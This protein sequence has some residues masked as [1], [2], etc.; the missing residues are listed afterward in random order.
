[1][2]RSSGLALLLCS[3]AGT[4][5]AEFALV[6]DYE[7]GLGSS[8]WSQAGYG[9]GTAEVVAD[10]IVTTG[11]NQVLAFNAGDVNTNN[12]TV[13][14]P[15]PNIVADSVGTVFYRVAVDSSASGLNASLMVSPLDAPTSYG[16]ANILLNPNTSGQLSYRNGSVYTPVVDP[17]DNLTWYKVWIVADT[18]TDTSDLYLQGGSYAVPTLVADDF[19]FRKDAV[20]ED[21]KTILFLANSGGA[22]STDPNYNGI[23]YVD[24][25]YVD[26]S[27]ANMADPVPTAAPAPNFTLVDNF[28]AGL[29][30][31]TVT[32]ASYGTGSA[33]I[34]NDPVPST[35]LYNKVLS[36]NAGD[37]N[38]NNLV[39]TTPIPNIVEG[40]YGTVF[41]RFAVDSSSSATNGTLAISPL[42]MPGVNV[43]GD[44]NILLN[45][46]TSE[47]ISYRDGTVYTPVVDPRENL[48]WYQA[49]YLIDTASDTSSLYL[50][51]GAYS[52]PTLVAED[53]AFRK[54]VT[55]EDLMSVM[56]LLNSG[57]AG[58]SV[59]NFNGSIFVDDIYVDNS[60][61]TIA[62]PLAGME[63]PTPT[64][65]F[66]KT[67]SSVTVDGTKDSAYAAR[68]SLVPLVNGEISG[69]A[70]LSASLSGTW[71]E[72][73]VYFFVDVTDDVISA[74]SG[75]ESF[76]D[77]SIEF[78]FDPGNDDNGSFDGV[79]DF[80]ITVHLQ[81]GT[82]P[83]LIT[84]S[85][86][87][88]PPSGVDFTGTEAA[89]VTTAGGYAVELFVPFSAL[90]FQPGGDAVLGFALQINDDDGVDT[91]DPADGTGER[92]GYITWSSDGTRL[93]S[94]TQ[95]FG[96]LWLWAP[97]VAEV[98]RAQGAIVIDG[99]RDG[100][101]NNQAMVNRTD[102]RWVRNDPIPAD[103]TSVT[104]RALYDED[105]L[106]LLFNV[107]DSSVIAGES[108]DI[109]RDDGIE[110]YFDGDNN[111]GGAFDGA[112]DVKITY[113]LTDL[114]GG[115]EIVTTA[116]FPSPPTGTDF[117]GLESA[118]KTTSSGWA[119]EVK[120]PWSIIGVTPEPGE[121]IGF[122]FLV[123]DD[124]DGGD[125]ENVLS[126]SS[127]VNL[128]NRT[129]AL[130]TLYLFAPLETTLPESDGS[131]IV[132]DG[133]IDTGYGSAP[134]NP[135]TRAPARASLPLASDLSA[136]WLGV[137][138]DSAIYLVVDVYDN[139]VSADS[140]S[141]PWQDDGIEFF[142]DP[143]NDSSGT[144]DGVEDVKIT[145]TLPLDG[146]D[147]RV[148]SATNFPSPPADTDFSGLE[149]AA[150]ETDTGWRV[151]LKVPL[152]TLRIGAPFGGWTMG[153]DIVISD[154]DFGG[155]RENNLAW[156]GVGLT[157]NQTEIYG[158]VTFEGE[159]RFAALS[160]ASPVEGETDTY[161]SWIGV[162]VEGDG[163]AGWILHEG[164][165]WLYVGPKNGGW[166]Y[167]YSL[168]TWIY[169]TPM[170]APYIFTLDQ[171]WT[172]YSYVESTASAYL[173]VYATQSWVAIP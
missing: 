12:L 35:S 27:G 66:L 7:D 85:N 2:A 128:N 18:T 153:M 92:S 139:D 131:A 99:D 4:A 109:W 39:V 26:A 54:N 169:S 136:W 88:T 123:N 101:F 62:N 96:N 38:T 56:F 11:D 130:G 144:F 114:E 14:T 80:K 74:D 122:G 29:D 9:T 134:W 13:V 147:L 43:W 42:E 118:Y 3:L 81:D 166:M 142:F 94:N 16:N 1:M 161:E 52:E 46:N 17:R 120:L 59:P 100:T 172:Y 110:L 31:F 40:S 93:N 24:D 23:V 76:K 33:T 41:L 95:E 151:E 127:G 173:Y 159:V 116:N 121:A 78:F 47:Q 73:G 129:D 133:T 163:Y 170:V 150:V 44:A 71:T 162:F 145:V 15:I 137:Y 53:F 63:N 149:A 37:V 148:V 106:Y 171:G 70:D 103:D 51:G 119:L 67:S 98:S 112:N 6:N 8:T 97:K 143:S 167:S 21:L 105:N 104:W 36:M 90:Q 28:E 68:R 158:D 111:K 25:L 83:I 5:Q 65:G 61:L 164:F 160:A 49:W 55:G 140:E 19:A 155:N 87:P 146:G 79:D 57:V 72:D 168:G 113:R 58:D 10:P 89:A 124:D 75:T 126:W 152:A 69:T 50:Q 108:T 45:P 48:T 30:G 154:D 84:T 34:V 82:D 107:T 86:F 32:Q 156:S 138:D 115:L 20:G 77:D 117:S 157:N 165:D 22:G 102:G 135:L 132:V 60:T 141:Q 91:S 125:R 64:T